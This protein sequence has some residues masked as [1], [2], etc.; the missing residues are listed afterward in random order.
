MTEMTPIRKEEMNCKMNKAV[1]LAEKKLTAKYTKKAKYTYRKQ[2][3]NAIESGALELRP[4]EDFVG[5]QYF[6]GKCDVYDSIMTY[7]RINVHDFEVKVNKTG[8]TPAELG[9]SDEVSIGDIS[10]SMLSNLFSSIFPISNNLCIVFASS[11]VVSV[12]LLAALPV[13]AHKTTFFL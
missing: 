12:I 9:D 3:R 5:G 11:P 8:L 7:F 6:S 4:E 13:G 1:E 10:I 2:V